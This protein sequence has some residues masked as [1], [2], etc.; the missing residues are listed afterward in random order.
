MTIKVVLSQRRYIYPCSVILLGSAYCQILSVQRM[1]KV[2][3]SASFPPL[4][5]ARLKPVFNN[6]VDQSNDSRP[7]DVSKE[8]FIKLRK[9]VQ[10]N[11]N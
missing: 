5:N 2:Q 3:C 7:C 8:L 6:Q 11:G 10:V 9:E 4:D 1:Y